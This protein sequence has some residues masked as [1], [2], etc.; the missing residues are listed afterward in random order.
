MKIFLT[1]VLLRNWKGL[2]NASSLRL[3]ELC[4][5]IN[6]LKS[7]LIL[8]APE[9]WVALYWPR[10]SD[11]VFVCPEM[12][13]CCS[14]A[15]LHYWW[16]NMRGLDALVNHLVFSVTWKKFKCST[17]LAVSKKVKISWSLLELEQKICHLSK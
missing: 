11:K 1:S 17:V 9:F 4:G 15:L 13:F 2:G 7:I 5:K 12:L 16:E 3:M 6:F 8:W 10:K 14:L